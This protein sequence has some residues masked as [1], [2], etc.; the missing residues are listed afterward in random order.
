MDDCVLQAAQ[1]T[2]SFEYSSFAPRAVE[3]KLSSDGGSAVSQRGFADE[4]RPSQGLGRGA[5]QG[6]K[7]DLRG[8]P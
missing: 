1:K 6:T 3:R 2:H 8:P 5:F 4:A 7:V